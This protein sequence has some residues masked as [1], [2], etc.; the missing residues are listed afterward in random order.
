MLSRQ[1]RNGHWHIGCKFTFL[2]L[3]PRQIRNGHRHVGWKFTFLLLLPR[4]IRNGHWHVGWKFTYFLLSHPIRN[5]RYW[6]EYVGTVGYYTICPNTKQLYSLS[7][8]TPHPPSPINVS[9]IKGKNIYAKQPRTHIL[10]DLFF[11]IQY[12]NIFYFPI[13]VRSLTSADYCAN[14]LSLTRT[15]TVSAAGISPKRVP[16]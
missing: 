5:G 10:S 9:E 11:K 13:N 1:I 4:Q 3:L 15:T 6:Y 12:L 16:H 8:S 14:S 7:S 2:L